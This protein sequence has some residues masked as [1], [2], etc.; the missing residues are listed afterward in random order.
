M[1]QLEQ[2]LTTG[3]GWQDQ[4]GAVAEGVK[5]ITGSPGLTPAMRLH[6]VTPEVLDPR[7]NGGTTLLYYTGVTRLAKNILE[8]VVGQY[9][10]R[11]RTCMAAL[12]RLHALPAEV[13]DAMAEKDAARFGR[14][15]NEVWECNKQLAATATNAEVE[16]LLRGSGRTSTARNC[17]GRRRRFPLDGLQVAAR[18]LA[19]PRVARI[20]PAQSLGA[21]LRFQHQHARAG[22]DG[23][24]K[25]RSSLP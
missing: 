12:R 21:V 18:R 19:S 5:V 25:R 16:A 11:G 17:W 6:F 13:S 4:I 23:V 9:L 1:L 2:L 22:R 8:Q 7:T 10:C 20:R 15:L 3:G 24:L 14:L